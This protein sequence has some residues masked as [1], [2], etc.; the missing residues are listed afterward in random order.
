MGISKDIKEHVSEHSINGLIRNTWVSGRGVGTEENCARMG[1][2]GNR[3]VRRCLAS[4][5]VNGVEDGG[6]GRGR[7]GG[8]HGEGNMGILTRHEKEYICLSFFSSRGR[9]AGRV[10][11]SGVGGP[12]GRALH[13]DGEY[14]LVRRSR[15]EDEK[16]GMKRMSDNLSKSCK[17]QSCKRYRKEEKMTTTI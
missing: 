3:K 12:V 9:L 1:V 17:S 11:G 14:A 2:R 10:M 5:Q 7:T 13:A 6:S 8:G 16:C 4:F 15:R